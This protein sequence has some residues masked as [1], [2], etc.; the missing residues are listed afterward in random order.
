MVFTAW[1]AAILP[2]VVTWTE[3]NSSSSLSVISNLDSRIAIGEYYLFRQEAEIYLAAG[4]RRGRDPFVAAQ[5]RIGLVETPVRP[6]AAARFLDWPD[7]RD[8]LLGLGGHYWVME[9]YLSAIVDG[10]TETLAAIEAGR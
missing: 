9:N 1:V 10:A 4:E 5:Y 8:D 6:E 7:M 2:P 3:L